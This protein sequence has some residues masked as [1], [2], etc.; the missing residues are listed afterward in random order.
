MGGAAIALRRGTIV[1]IDRGYCDY[2]WFAELT[3]QGAYSV[4]RL[5][6]NAD[7]EVVEELARTG[8]GRASDCAPGAVRDSPQSLLRENENPMA[9]GDGSRGRQPEFGDGTQ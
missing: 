4:T 2:E 6:D 8:G 1:A 7:Y 9:S 3:K 5:K